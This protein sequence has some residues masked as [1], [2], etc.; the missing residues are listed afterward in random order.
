MNLFFR[1]SK[2]S[3]L[4]FF[5]SNLANWHFSCRERYNVNWIN[6][7]GELTNNERNLLQEFGTIMKK[8]G[9]VYR[10]GVLQYLGKFFLSPRKDENLTW[11][12]IKNHIT[13]N[14]Y[15]CIK[16]ILTS[17]ENRFNKVWNVNKLDQWRETLN[18]KTEG[19]LFEK[20]IQKISRTLTGAAKT[21]SNLDIGVSLLFSPCTDSAPAGGANLGSQDV[22]LEV[23]INGMTEWNV[24][25]ALSVL[26]HEIGHN[27]YEKSLLRNIVE[28]QFASESLDVDHIT[29]HR[30]LTEL[31]KEILIGCCAPNGYLVSQC[32]SHFSPTELLAENLG[33]C[34]KSFTNF[35]N[36]KETSYWHFTSYVIWLL[37]PVVAFYCE[38]DMPFD[39]KFVRHIVSV[40]K[41]KEPCQ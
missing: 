32:F 31:I 19:D 17:F 4:F 38:H 40:L 15:E 21:D 34:F 3:N 13:S 18:K 25:C 7:T 22:T 6:Q 20:L 26:L 23:P 39:E 30:P 24:E 36:G 29:N 16:S 28:K 14:E 41:N 37:Y 1:V 10:N 12:D 35:Q 11:N 9:F 5:V 2:L 8:Y 33:G 27:L